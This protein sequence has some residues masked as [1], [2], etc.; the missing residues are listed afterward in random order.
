M[1]GHG[2]LMGCYAWNKEINTKNVTIH[3][4]DP[5]N[6]GIFTLIY[7]VIDYLYKT[8]LLFS[9]APMETQF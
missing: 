4:S 3:L 7:V 8:L 5:V 9:P 1:L 2:P 6:Y